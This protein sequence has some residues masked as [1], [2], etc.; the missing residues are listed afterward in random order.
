ME[1][2]KTEVIET[3]EQVETTESKESIDSS[4]NVEL[5]TRNKPQSELISEKEYDPNNEEDN[6]SISLPTDRYNKVVDFIV[7]LS[8]LTGEFHKEFITDKHTI[9][10]DISIR[11]GKNSQATDVFEEALDNPENEFTNNFE[12]SDKVLAPNT[13]KINSKTDILS[14][15][16]AI[17]FFSKALGIG[18]LVEVPLWHSGFWVTLRPPKQSE[19][20]VLES[21]I[22]NLSVQLGALTSTIIYSNY[23]VIAIRMLMDFIKDHIQNSSLKLSPED[24]ILDYINIQDLQPLVL[25]III[26]MYPKGAP[27]TRICVNTIVLDSN[28]IP[29]CDYS[30]RG[31]LDPKKLLFVNRKALSSEHINQMIKRLPNSV[32]IDDVKNYQLTLDRIKP[33]KIE[34]NTEAED[35]KIN[36]TISL[37]SIKE[38]ITAGEE[39][40]NDI[41]YKSEELFTDA[42][43]QETKNKKVDE[44]LSTFI[45]GLYSTFITQIEIEY[46]NEGKRV[47]DKPTIINLLEAFSGDRAILKE[48]IPKITKFITD[49]AVAIVATPTFICPK[50]K[51]NQAVSE[52]PAFRELIPLNIIESFFDLST[53]RGAKLRSIDMY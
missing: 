52:N 41:I 24:D 43:N 19:I 31:V 8:K 53:L 22:A 38:Y 45:L 14:N 5:N 47:I 39:W 4:S 46:A 26:S 11:G 51:A 32:T 9:A 30:I 35:V 29:K 17:A 10:R 1:E 3:T 7:E 27:I 37:P 42:D 33:H 13:L 44:M 34:F 50:C 49:T 28:N 2:N 18:E 20:I 15:Q 36:L 21:N 23:S 48:Y 25:G 16:N 12:H 6:L 40:V